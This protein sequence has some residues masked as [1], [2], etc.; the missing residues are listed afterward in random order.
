M[1][2]AGI[3]LIGI[4]LGMILVAGWFGL[5]RVY[6]QPMMGP[7]GG[8]MMQMMGTQTMAEMKAEMMRDPQAMGTMAAA[9]AQAMNN[10]RD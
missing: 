8:M 6:G 10:P 1:R 5:S 9:C 3:L 2:S 7:T 4:A